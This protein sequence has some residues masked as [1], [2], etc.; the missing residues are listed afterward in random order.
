MVT[1]VGMLD[2]TYSGYFT[3]ED[4]VHTWLAYTFTDLGNNF[5]IYNSS[6]HQIFSLN[7]FQC[8]SLIKLSKLIETELH[9]F[10]A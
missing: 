4:F 6:P 1:L 5:N 8:K 10:A 9:P 2:E 3:Y 7:Q